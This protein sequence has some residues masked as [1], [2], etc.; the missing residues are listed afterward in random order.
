[1]DETTPEQEIC[2]S[3]TQNDDIDYGPLEDYEPNQSDPNNSLNLDEDDQI[4]NAVASISDNTMTNNMSPNPELMNEPTLT[5]TICRMKT[6]CR[7]RTL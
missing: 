6:L 3:T 2:Q 5:K 7:I 1:M 4:Q